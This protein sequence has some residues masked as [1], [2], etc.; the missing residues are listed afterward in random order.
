MLAKVLTAPGG[1]YMLDRPSVFLAGPIQDAP[2]WQ[3]EVIEKL[4]D[5]RIAI[6]NPRTPDPWHGDYTG[7]VRWE[8]DHLWAASVIMFW[9]AN[10]IGTPREGRSYAQTSRFELGEWF[11]RSSKGGRFKLVVGI[12]PGF[13]GGRYIST[14]LAE[15]TGITTCSSL[16]DTV[17]EVK[18]MLDPL[19]RLV[20]MDRR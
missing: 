4:E 1:L 11:S 7:Q 13:P 20:G 8:T 16:E 14:R 6:Y 3:A 9:L 10:P 19:E 2:D 12:E 18:A 17:Q 5:R 15:V